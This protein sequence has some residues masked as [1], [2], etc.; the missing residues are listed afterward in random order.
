MQQPPAPRRQPQAKH[1]TA[2]SVDIAALAWAG[3]HDEAIRLADAALAEPGLDAAARIE[4]LDHRAESRMAL[5]DYAGAHDDAVAMLGLARG[6][7][8]PALL[9]RALCRLALMQ[10]RQEKAPQHVETAQAA[11]RAARVARQPALEALSLFRLSEAQFRSGLGEAALLNAQRCV[12]LFASLGDT[13]WQ[14]RALWAQAHAHDRLGQGAQREQA[15]RQ[16]LALAEAAGDQLGIGAALNI[17]YREHHAIGQRLMG[18]KQSYAAFRAAGYVERY[19]GPLGNLGLTYSALGLF[20]QAR[21]LAMQSTEADRNQ[22]NRHSLVAFAVQLSMIEARL[23]HL[24]EHKRLTL[25][26]DTLNRGLGDHWFDSVVHWLHGMSAALQGQPE[27]ACR[28]YDMALE[29]ARQGKGQDSTQLIIVLSS[30]GQARLEAGDAAAALTATQQAV[31]LLR[32]RRQQ[33]IGSAFA[34]ATAWWWHAR[35]LQ[36]NGQDAAARDALAIG[37]QVML[38]GVAGVRDEGLRRSWFN[39]VEA[40]RQLIRAWLAQPRP[41]LAHLRANTSVHEPFERLVDTGLRLNELQHADALYEFVVEEA[42]ELS[43]AERVLLVLDGAEGVRLAAGTV[44]LGEDRAVL[45]QAITPWLEEARRSR[46]V[47]LRHGP[48][49]TA[50]VQQR[51]CL[52][53]PLI[54]QRELLGYL[55]ADIDGA[56]GRFGDADRDLL[57]MLAAQ[58]AVALAHIRANAGLEAKVAERTAEAQVARGRAEQRAGELALINRIQQG[59]A[60]ELRF[61]AVVDLVGD[62]L[63]EVFTERDVSIFWW[64]AA[65]GLSHGLYVRL[66]G[67]RVAVQPVR[68]D[69]EGRIARAFAQGQTVVANTQ[70]E[71]AAWGMRAMQGK[72]LALSTALVPIMLGERRI[73]T[74]G[75]NDHKRENAFGE[76]EVGLLQTVAASLGVGLEN[77]RL[78]DDAQRL[79]KETEQ[80]ASELAVI[81]SIQQGMAANLSLQ[82]IIDVVGD[83]L[84]ELFDSDD[85]AITAIEEASGM[86]H[87][88]YAIESG[89]RLQIPP[90]PIESQAKII[91]VLK[92]GRPLLVK[93]RATAVAYGIRTVPGT[94]PSR[95][96]VF[97]PVMVGQRLR[98]A[99]RLVSLEREDAFDEATVRML[100]T[101]AASMGVALENVRLFNE[102]KEALE[103]QTATAE[104]LQVISSSVADTQPVF[105]R[106][107]AGCQRLFAGNWHS[108]FV[109][110][111]DRR[112]FRLAA[113]HGVLGDVLRRFFPLPL[114][115]THPLQQAIR[116]GRVLRYDNVLEGPDVIPDVRRVIQ[117]MNFGNCSQVFMPLMW[118]GRGIGALVMVRTPPEPFDDGDIAQLKTFADQAVIAIQNAH[119]FRETQEA[120]SRQTATADIL[121]VI[122]R[123]PTAVQPVFEA[124]VGTASKLLTSDLAIML[125]CDG[126]T[127]SPVAGATPDGPLSDLGPPVLPVDP[128]ANFPSRAIVAKANLQLS[129]WNAIDLPEHERGMQ[130]LFGVRSSLMLPL[131][132]EGQCIGVLAFARK[133]V[134]TYSDKEIALAEA[135]RDQALIAI[136]NTQLF[137][138]TQESLQ[139]Q[140]ASAEVLAVISSSVS[141]AQP[142]FEKILDSCKHLFG[143]DELDV[144]LVDEQGQL[145]IAAYR[146]V[147]HDI[148]AATFPAPVERTPAGR[149]LRERRVMHWPDLIDGDDVPGVLRKMAKLIGYRSMVFAPMLWNERGIGAIGVARSTGPFKPKELDMLQTFADQAVIAIQNARLFNETKEALEHQTATAEVLRVVNRSLGDPQ[150]V[151]ESIVTSM[152]SVLPGAELVVS[153]RGDDGMIHWRAGSGQRTDAMHSLFPRPAPTRAMLTGAAT[154]FPDLL[155]GDG[156]PDSLRAAARALGGNASMLSAAMH[157]GE[158]VFGAILAFRLDMRP[159]T[160]KEGRV[161]KTFADQA[162]IAI[163]NA[164]LFNETQEALERQTATAEVLRVISQSPDDVQPVF[165]AIAERAKL[166]CN[167]AVS[168]VARYDGRLVHL[169]AYQGV[170]PEADAAMRALFPVPVSA[171][172]IT[173]RAIRERVPV[174]TAD[175]MADANYAAKEAAR[176]SGYR[177][178]LAV[179]MLHDGSVIGS[180]A[181]CR[182]EV[183]L[184]PDNQVKLLQTFADQA[185]IAVE[186][187]RLFKETQEA[188]AHQTASAE[189]LQVISSSVAD[190]QPVFDKILQSC[191]RLFDSQ[192]VS[193]TLVDDHD[194]VQL[195]ADMG[196][197]A[198]STEF[199]KGFYPL[200][201]KASLQGKAIRERRVLHY[202][203]VLGGDNVPEGLRRV[204]QAVGNFSVLYAPLLWEGRGVGAIVVNRFPPMPFTDKEI[205]LLKTFADQAV[206]AI[207]NARLFNETQEALEL[208]TTSAEV[209][210]VVGE[211]MA[212]AQPVF[213]SVCASLERLLPGTELAISARESDGRL[214]WRAGSGEHAEAL[215]QLFPRPAPGKLITGVP[216]LWP[217]LAHGPDVPDSLREAT[218]ILG[219]NASMLSAAMTSEGEV[220]G[221]LSALRFDMRPFTDNE[222]RVIKTFADQAVV[223]IQNARLFN[224]TKE[225]LEQQTATAEVLQ[226]IS[227]SVSDTT[228]VFDKILRSCMSLFDN[229]RVNLGLI[230]DDGLMH[231]IQLDE[232]LN[233]PDEDSRTRA[234]EFQSRFPA[235]VDQTIQGHVISMAS[236]AHYPDVMNGAD[237]PQGLRRSAEKWGNYSALF[238]PLLW[239]GRGIGALAVLRF[240]PSPFSEREIALLKT[241]ADQAV[242]A[243]Q[244][245]RLFKETQEARA[246]AEAANEAKSAFLATMSH[247]IRTPMNAVIGMSGLLLDTPLNDEQRDFAS[248]IRDSGDS[249]LT[250]INDILDFSKI[251]AGRM[252]I[253]AHPFDLRDCVESALDLIA[254]RAAEKHLDIAYVFEGEVPPVINGDVTRLR[255]ILLNLFS[256]AVK[257]TEA[258]E[259]VLSVA[260]EQGEHGALLHF[261]VRDTGI[262]L[263]EQGKGRLFQKFSQADSSTTRKYGGTGLGLAIS[264]LL[265]ELMGGTMWVESAGPGTGSTFHFTIASKPAA[266]PQGQD[267]RKRE[268]IGEQAPLKGKRLLVVDDN[269]TNRRILAL[270][271]AKWGMVAI[272]TDAPEKALPLLQQQHFDLAILDMHMPGMDGLQ[273]AARIRE[274]GHSLP[275]VLFTSLG[276][277]ENTS[278]L[279]AASLAKP[280]HQSQL[281]DTLV[282]LLA[283]DGPAR[284]AAPSAPKPRMDAGMAERHPL[285]ILLAEDNVVNQKLAL[286]LLQQMGYRADVAGNGIEAIECIER[287]PYDVVLM[288]VQMP[289]MDGLEAS[290]RI[291]ARWPVGERP[292]IIAMTA[293][294]MQGDREECLA[295]GMDDYVTKPIRVDTLVQALLAA[296]ARRNG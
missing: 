175:V 194:M 120:L 214:H 161:L 124:V 116:E 3:R 208:Q 79:L 250:I 231:M 28:H 118:E 290:R 257:F 123:S 291:T 39:K 184:F 153:A 223:A 119:M 169:V 11:L 218:R 182:A 4:L 283:P 114:S 198:E 253:E 221:A 148:V 154:H 133:R 49:G 258:G 220:V 149:A 2:H 109:L 5:S 40:H 262:G 173:A 117:G 248:T 176:L 26:A 212:D 101:V 276:R 81:N 186:N 269:A 34:P 242:I 261:A 131:L 162:G 111:E 77:A 159:F 56:F 72:Q 203:D 204:G 260:P 82:A 267:A 147:A 282:T 110:D 293:N 295:S 189:V 88:V 95:S 130:T 35:A 272:D 45:L 233:S 19:S 22:G 18:L 104:V 196:S 160:E 16:A 84:R 68:P 234:R 30:L 226:V 91:D 294:A 71:M 12:A 103:Q 44:P 8:K 296:G 90:F 251:E 232:V 51:S 235:P 193:I 7:H 32:A 50:V 47:S 55:Y 190:A 135:F 33:G 277:Q 215:R 271:T 134:D 94:V 167:A 191:Q 42:T 41:K 187:V 6:A 180:I 256:N 83:R 252:D 145:N 192:R 255:Q 10:T 163:Q 62:T 165:E 13:V 99:I 229:S 211:S 23:G 61:Q 270:Q 60:A 264:K 89:Q 127:F 238:A 202:P 185:V 38:G 158:T 112:E 25:Q 107:L 166:L 243:I 76:A 115:D 288:D 207:Q 64:D 69:P 225:A 236:V 228:P 27:L 15:A 254:S 132:H 142:V 21:R 286:R 178:N 152:Q 65:A 263:T 37:Y 73:G 63:S 48:A 31:E 70:E 151:F 93:D 244:N 171:A 144:L 278:G 227:S 46:A 168:G 141:D 140:K 100:S 246:A 128:A 200:P 74:L 265:A 289:E 43:G 217:D 170:S 85:I 67:Q 195:T 280:L 247:E 139:Q 177:S 279:F 245:A 126:A 281:F 106:I 240:P 136:Q 273:L 92:T 9:A 17:L 98:L 66:H 230:R 58:A 241:F 57:A 78:F 268:L 164:R 157:A 29:I 199:T 150:P 209:L 96:S 122:S 52:I 54:A 266:L 205:A 146:G 14:G 36:A 20:A 59:I 287:Q 113:H 206:I 292:R 274:A 239:E 108:V 183:G 213:D 125:R 174:Q 237:V 284:S 143:G 249:L 24:D 179:P 80:R 53:A 188:L 137:N 75:L 102:T 105:E 129:D 156:V 97:V 181:V 285:R 219:C 222:S 201:L 155:H 1:A 210:R 87:S 275:L 172:T 121:R 86:L 216:S 224:E 138:E 259:V 197:T